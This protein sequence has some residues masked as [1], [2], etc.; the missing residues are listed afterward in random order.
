MLS[1]VQ[2]QRSSSWQ[3]VS[4]V[5]LLLLSLAGFM[6]FSSM[7]NTAQAQNAAVVECDGSHDEE[8][9]LNE[10]VGCSDEASAFS[11]ETRVSAPGVN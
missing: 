4:V 8:A 3:L 2:T 11:D 7:H 9:S 10:S 5:T 6:I 1:L